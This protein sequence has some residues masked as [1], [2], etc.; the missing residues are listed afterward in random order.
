VVIHSIQAIIFD[1]GGVIIDLHFDKM[2]A[3]FQKLGLHNFDE[4]FTK[5]KQHPVLDQFD[6]GL[7]CAQEFKEQVC[8]SAGIEMSQEEF[9]GAWN[10][11]LGEIPSHKISFLESLKLPIFLLSNTNSIHKAVFDR[12]VRDQFGKAGIAAYFKKAYFSHEMGCRKP[13]AEIFLRVIEENGLSV[14]NTL[15]IDD[16]PQHVEAARKLG[17]IGYHLQ[18]GEDISQIVPSLLHNV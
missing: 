5:L 13:D 15:F 9:E 7:V 3:E 10:A 18:D 16:S 4:Y 17:L 1:F 14:S 6:K 2:R 11:I 12:Y 8:L